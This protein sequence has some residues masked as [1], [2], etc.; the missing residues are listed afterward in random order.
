[1]FAGIDFPDAFSQD[2]FAQR[3]NNSA[4]A[5]NAYDPESL[6]T[7]AEVEQG[8]TYTNSRRNWPSELSYH[9][10]VSG[11]FNCDQVPILAPRVPLPL[12]HGEPRAKRF[13]QAFNPREASWSDIRTA[14]ELEPIDKSI[15]KQW[16][17]DAYGKWRQYDVTD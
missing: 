10:T 6:I 3:R 11:R 8:L 2:N 4:A 16:R 1:M 15:K 14:C 7:G 12:T 13:E 9:A 5:G 17:Y